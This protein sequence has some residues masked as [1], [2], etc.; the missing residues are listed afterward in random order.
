MDFSTGMSYYHN[1]IPH[2]KIGYDN[3]NRV[4][5]CRALIRR[6]LYL[7][8]HNIEQDG[9]HTIRIGGRKMKMCFHP[10]NEILTF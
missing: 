2:K 8:F 3:E 7:K 4:A 1:Q 5:L 6:K 10:Q 9:T